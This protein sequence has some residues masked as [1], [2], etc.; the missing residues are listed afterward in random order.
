MN[1]APFALHIGVGYANI[2]SC[3]ARHLDIGK[4]V[5]PI[6]ALLAVVFWLILDA[7]RIERL[8]SPECSGM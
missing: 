7:G 3:T 8:D 6:L 1:A 5:L 4:A 2:S